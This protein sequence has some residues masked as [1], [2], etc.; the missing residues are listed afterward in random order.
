MPLPGW[1]SPISVRSIHAFLE[2]SAL[3]CFAALVV[4]DV[5][6]HFETKRKRLFERI[7]LIFFALAVLAEIVAYPYSKRNDEFSTGEIARLNKVAEAERLARVRLEAA[8]AGRELTAEQ[9]RKIG[10]AL[11]KFSGRIVWL[12]SYPGD[13]EAKRLG[14]QV[15]TALDLAHIKVQDRLEEM[16]SNAPLIFGIE[17]VCAANG[18]RDQRHFA[19]ALIATLSGDVGKL[20]VHPLSEF[21]CPSEGITEI[22]IGV[23]PAALAK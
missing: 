17:V 15:K 8:I 12:R 3:L 7:A 2:V 4:F 14:I 5:V 16:Y 22:H 13:G 19:R 9:Q 23:K 11:E 18:I 6:A 21:A 20:D 1:N 10:A